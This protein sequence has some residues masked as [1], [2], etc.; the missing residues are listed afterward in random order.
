[1]KDNRLEVAQDFTPSLFIVTSPFQGLCAIE[2]INALQIRKYKI[3]ACVDGSERDQQLFTFFNALDL[4]FETFNFKKCNIVLQII[5]CVFHRKNHGYKRAFLGD[6]D[7]M[8]QRLVAYDCLSLDSYIAYVDDGTKDIP[9][10]MGLRRFKRSKI[11]FLEIIIRKILAIRITKFHFTLFSDIA[12]SQFNCRKNTFSYTLLNL[13]KKQLNKK[14]IYFIG[15]NSRIY[16]DKLGIPDD[17]YL[18][19]LHMQLDMLA[20]S[21]GEQCVKYIPHGRDMQNELI[22]DICLNVGVC[23]YPINKAVELYIISCS[24]MPVAIYGYTSTKSNRN[25]WIHSAVP[26]SLYKSWSV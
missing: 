24:D 11:W 9:Y 17:V 22:K 16:C 21:Y 3:I 5:K 2:A 19:N 26:K 4:Q 20:H 7:S 18:K 8:W 25:D 23:Y 13:K 10:L 14:D 15:T 6:V 1:M 12:I